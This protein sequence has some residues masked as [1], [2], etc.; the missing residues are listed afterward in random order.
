MTTQMPRANAHAY[1]LRV[2]AILAQRSRR[3]TAGA[4]STD[5]PETAGRPCFILFGHP[6][7]AFLRSQSPQRDASRKLLPTSLA[8]LSADEDR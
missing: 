2:A 6:R 1:Q 8:R 3:C 7:G 5:A 4:F